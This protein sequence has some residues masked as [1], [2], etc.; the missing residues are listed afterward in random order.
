[1]N[2]TQ[3][4]LI[5]DGLGPQGS[6][7]AGGPCSSNTAGVSSEPAAQQQAPDNIAGLHSTAAAYHAKPQ[8]TL[9]DVFQAIQAHPWP[10]LTLPHV[11]SCKH[12]G[13]SISQQQLQQDTHSCIAV[14][15]LLRQISSASSGGG[16]N[17]ARFESLDSLAMVRLDNPYERRAAA[18]ADDTQA[19]AQA[20]AYVGVYPSAA[21]SRAW[22]SDSD[23]AACLQEP[24]VLS[25]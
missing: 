11:Q 23:G 3:Q 22:S 24:C 20:A 13:S 5:P 19:A 17:L 25:R 18:V 14:P 6:S 15:R 2:L 16:S 1:M 8:P 21:V 9:A 10:A 12:G 4:F 7:I